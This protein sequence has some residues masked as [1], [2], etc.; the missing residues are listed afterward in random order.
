MIL[1]GV[2][3]DGSEEDP[4]SRLPRGLNLVFLH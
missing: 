1:L 4:T 2:S 3:E